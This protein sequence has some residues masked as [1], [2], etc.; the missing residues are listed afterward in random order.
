MREAFE[1]NDTLSYIQTYKLPPDTQVMNE[2]ITFQRNLFVK[3]SRYDDYY[4][5]PGNYTSSN[6]AQVAEVFV[7]YKASSWFGKA[8]YR[9]APYYGS[10]S[11]SYDFPNDYDKITSTD[12]SRKNIGQDYY[13]INSGAT[14]DFQTASGSEDYMV[15]VT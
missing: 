5:K 4:T 10:Y 8:W 11:H 6:S 12:S 13:F 9:L 14:E 3:R 1:F 2:Y 15:V 7:N